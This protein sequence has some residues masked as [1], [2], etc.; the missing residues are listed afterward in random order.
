[1][2]L[3]ETDTEHLPSDFGRGIITGE[4]KKQS[5][6][7]AVG[8]NAEHSTDAPPRDIKMSP[9]K[10]RSME[11]FETDT[12]HLPSD[13]GRGI[14]TGEAKKQSMHH[15]VGANAEHSTDAPPRDIKMS[16]LKIRS[17]ELFETDTEH[18]PSDFGRGIITGEAK[19][20]SMH[21]AVGANAEHST[22]APPRDIKMSPLKIQSMEFFGLYP[23]EA[24][25]SLASTGIHELLDGRQVGI[26][27]AGR[28]VYGSG[29]Q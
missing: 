13:F 14:I 26:N 27:E 10:I 29:P 2:E 5:M 25:D 15:A 18:L 4:A 24:L 16:P 8:A 12:E 23:L 21:H 19:K 17:M 20:Q 7:H 22:D 9:L 3:F 11:L 6:H 1:M 28:M